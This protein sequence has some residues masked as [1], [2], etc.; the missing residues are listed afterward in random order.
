MERVAQIRAQV[1]ESHG[2]DG[3]ACARSGHGNRRIQDAIVDAV[4][5]RE[6]V[7]STGVDHGIGV[8]AKTGAGGRD[9]AKT[10]AGGGDGG[11]VT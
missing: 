1:R 5:G 3:G 2:V 11:D 7:G 6:V 10:S 9:G 4:D 8:G